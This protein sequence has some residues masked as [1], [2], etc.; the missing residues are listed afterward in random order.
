M[1][2]FIVGN[3]GGCQYAQMYLADG[4]KVTDSIEKADL[5]QFTGGADVSPELYKCKQ[6]PQSMCDMARDKHEQEI[7]H[8]CIEQNKPMVGI[9][10]GGQFLNVMNGGRMYQHVD[11]HGIAGTHKASCTKSGQLINVTSTHHQMM[12]PGPSGAVQLLVE[13]SLTTRK[14]YVDEQGELYI[15]Q[16]DANESDVESV[17]YPHTNCLCF[18]PHPEYVEGEACREYFFSLVMARLFNDW[19]RFTKL[20][21]YAPYDYAEDE[22]DEDYEE[23]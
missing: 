20:T 23:D 4:W 14:E 7:Y 10:R 1:K 15:V 22:E 21:G 9:C 19:D 5:V 16:P 11:N 6:H 13:K 2:V 3:R 18:Q 12:I 8:I 17:L